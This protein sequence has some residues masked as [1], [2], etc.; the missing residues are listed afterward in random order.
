[1][2]VWIVSL[3]LSLSINIYIYI[4]IQEF[5][6]HCGMKLLADVAYS[7]T[8]QATVERS[9]RALEEMLMECRGYKVSRHSLNN[10]LLTVN[11]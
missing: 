3:S 1:M 9:S 5:Y 2:A 8:S 11:S 6:K 7:P 10:A 4:R